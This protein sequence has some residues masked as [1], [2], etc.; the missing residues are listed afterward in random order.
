MA[1][2]R[3]VIYRTVLPT[4]NERDGQYSFDDGARDGSG[5]SGKIQRRE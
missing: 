3:I 1:R 2:D 5:R 4:A